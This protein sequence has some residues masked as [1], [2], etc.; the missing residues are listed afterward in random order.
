M[1]LKM[2][3]GYIG[4]R[5]QE[6][7]DHAFLRGG[8]WMVNDYKTLKAAIDE[9]FNYDTERRAHESRATSSECPDLRGTK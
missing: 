8:R 7:T 1:K 2:A 3:T 5:I 6:L 9:V 4:G